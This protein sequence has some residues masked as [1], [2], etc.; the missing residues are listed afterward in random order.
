MKRT[1]HPKQDAKKQIKLH[2]KEFLF[3]RD[4]LV[5]RMQSLK[6]KVEAAKIVSGKIGGKGLSDKEIKEMPITL[7]EENIR[8][9]TIEL[10]EE[11]ITLHA[12]S[13]FM[14]LCGRAVEYYSSQ[15]KQDH[16][17]Y[18]ALMKRMLSQEKIQKVSAQLK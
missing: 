1:F 11:Q 12:V 15:G 4:S 16:L 13:A 14:N 18:L 5:K 2:M 17:R 10:E 9:L 3:F 7:V 6:I 8:L